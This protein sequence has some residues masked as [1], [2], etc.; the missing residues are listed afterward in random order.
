MT[1]ACRQYQEEEGLL[2]GSNLCLPDVQVAIDQEV[3]VTVCSKAMGPPRG[4]LS[5][6]GQAVQQ[7]GVS[8]AIVAALDPDCLQIAEHLR[9]PAFQPN[10]QARPEHLATYGLFLDLPCCAGSPRRTWLLSEM[11]AEEKLES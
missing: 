3:L 9:M 4:L 5:L 6:W 2:V 1:K 10:L 11:P 8:N 7:A